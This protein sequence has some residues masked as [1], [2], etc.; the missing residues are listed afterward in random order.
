MTRRVGGMWGAASRTSF[1]ICFLAALAWAG[2]CGQ[3]DDP[4]EGGKGGET[5]AFA[6]SPCNGC[7]VASCQSEV[8]ACSADPGCAAYLDCLGHCPVAENG[9]ADAACDDAC[10]Q[11]DATESA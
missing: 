2:A 8:D 7:V 10:P 11:G 3:G 1:G 6:T 5:Q 9:D 4:G